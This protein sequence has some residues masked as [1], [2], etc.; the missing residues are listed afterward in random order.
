MGKKTA[1]VVIVALVLLVLYACLATLRAGVRSLERRSRE[2]LL[3]KLVLA[4]PG[5][6]LSE[7]R[8]EL[9]RPMGEWT[10]PED[11]LAWGRV[12]DKAFCKEKKL[13]RFYVST[14]PCRAVD[15]YT[16]A[17]DVIVYATWVGL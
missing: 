16:D 10:K 9:G 5:I 12:N 6:R 8:G 13:S 4:K 1:I 7:V 15:V 2:E 14:P 11:I 17:N 3:Q